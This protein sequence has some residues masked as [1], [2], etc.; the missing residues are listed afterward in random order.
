M[1]AMMKVELQCSKIAK[2][3]RFF[4]FFSFFY[5]EDRRVMICKGHW[6][7]EQNSNPPLIL[8]YGRIS[9]PL[10]CRGALET[11]SPGERASLQLRV[12]GRRPLY[13]H[14]TSVVPILRKALLFYFWPWCIA[15]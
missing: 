15:A 12:G 1:T 9:W 6:E 11:V 13:G 7:E 5:K 14:V 2:E 3:K 10:Y 4:F 8:K